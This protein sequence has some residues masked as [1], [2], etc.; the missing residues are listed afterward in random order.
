[1]N[2]SYLVKTSV[3]ILLVIGALVGKNILLGGAKPIKLKPAPALAGIVSQSLA[4]S[5]K[6]TS[7]PQPG[8][9]F[10]LENIRYFDNNTW[11]I[12]GLK[13]LRDQFNSGVVVLKNIDGQYEVV[14]GPGSAFDSSYLLSLP[15]DVGNYLKTQGAIYESVD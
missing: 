12:A 10:R 4:A 8:K 1:M 9:D 6:Q 13:P 3:L 5:S 11:V 15:S 7:L 14:L 2:R